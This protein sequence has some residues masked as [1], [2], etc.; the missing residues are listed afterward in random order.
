MGDPAPEVAVID[1][2]TVIT[3]G[4]AYENVDDAHIPDLQTD[5]FELVEEADPP[6]VVLNLKNT[7]FFGSAFIEVLFRVH[8]RL[9]DRNGQFGICCLT[10]YC[11][12]VIEI[13]HL[14]RVWTVEETQAEAVAA[15]KDAT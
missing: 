6:L 15:V 14:D 12:E 4:P 9:K 8:N 10:R 13:T 11:A 2:V 1:G 5:F 7:R 3:L